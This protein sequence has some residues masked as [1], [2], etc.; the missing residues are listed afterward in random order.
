M[1][2]RGDERLDRPI[3]HGHWDSS[4][5]A[6]LED[7]SQVGAGRVGGGVPHGNGVEERGRGNSE[8]LR[9]L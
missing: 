1:L 5:H 3:L 9:G 4:L 2:E 7:G 6:D 8:W